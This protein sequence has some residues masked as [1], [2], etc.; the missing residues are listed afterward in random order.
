[1]KTQ[2]PNTQATARPWYVVRLLNGNFIGNMIDGPNAHSFV[3][4]TLE[5]AVRFTSFENAQAAAK[6]YVGVDGYKI[7]TEQEVNTKSFSTKAQC[8]SLTKEQVFHMLQC[9]EACLY[10]LGQELHRAQSAVAEAAKD[11]EIYY[12]LPA[13]SRH[14]EISE[15]KLALSQALS[16][17]ATLRNNH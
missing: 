4:A 11:I 3:M 1:M 13:S 17:L 15:L 12:N 16:A 9:A 8:D 14:I 2:T 5:H 6:S 10:K 7:Y